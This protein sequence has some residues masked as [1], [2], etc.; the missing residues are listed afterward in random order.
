MLTELYALHNEVMATTPVEFKRAL[1]N[2]VNWKNHAICILGHRGVGKTTLL[3]QRL[4]DE[5]KT[6]D[7]GLY[8]SA[9]NVFVLN[10]GLFKT[11][12]NYFSSGGEAIFIDEVHKYPG[13]SVEVKNIIDTYKRKKIII[14]GSSSIDLVKSKG[15]LSRRVVYY[16]L[17]GMSFREYLKLKGVIDP[18]IYTLNEILKDHVEIAKQFTSMGILK[19]FYNYLSYGYYPIFTE[20]TED[21]LVKILNVIDKVIYEDIAV[22]FNLKQSTLILMKKLLSLIAT[23]DGLVPNIDS[24]SKQLQVTRDSVYDSF[25]YLNQAGLISNLYLDERG[26]KMIRK[27]GKVFLNN[28]N[29][30]HAITGSLRIETNT[31]AIRETLFASQLA[32]NHRINLHPTAD[33]VVDGEFI[34]EV[35]GRNKSNS[36]L[37][38]IEKNGYLALDGIE[39]GYKHKIPLYLFGLLY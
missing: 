6:D 13:W 26:M 16:T 31:G 33:F 2:Q 29:L 19:H 39:V 15:D 28:T 10:E 35:G 17:P 9:D 32:I 8:I 20:G 21:Y 25:E 3:C 18:P 34:F 27:P 22:I 24:I 14:S 38:G 1:Y 4:L 30:L 5:Y 36:Q 11:A 7:K 37:K 23:V 12:M